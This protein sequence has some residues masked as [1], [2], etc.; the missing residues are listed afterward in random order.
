MKFTRR[1]F[2]YIYL[3]FK[4]EFK[5]NYLALTSLKIPL[6]LLYPDRGKEQRMVLKILHSYHELTVSIKVKYDHKSPDSRQSIDGIRNTCD[7]RP[8]EG[9]QTVLEIT[10]NMQK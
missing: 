2:I 9:Y 8:Y 3:Q 10:Q 4:S 6:S 5:E 1:F 7:L